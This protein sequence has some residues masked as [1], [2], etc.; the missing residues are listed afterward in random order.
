MKIR[1]DEASAAQLR[2]FLKER[3]GIDR[4]HTST[5]ASLLKVIREVGETG[6]EFELIGAPTPTEPEAATEARPAPGN[7]QAEPDDDDEEPSLSPEALVRALMDQGMAEDQAREI[8]GLAKN[9]YERKHGPD[10]LP[11]GPGK[12]NLYVTVH[13]AKTKDKF[14]GEPVSVVVNG[15]RID[16]PRG[17]DWP[18]RTPY[19][20]NLMHSEEIVYEEVVIA[21]H[22]PREYRP[23][24]VQSYPVR[25]ITPVPYDQAEARRVS[26]VATQELLRSRPHTLGMVAAA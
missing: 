17:V 2:A 9:A 15:D 5:R 20:E 13:I 7:G 3:Y 12:E 24:Y 16:I 18:I 26:Q 23:K 14:G 19:F 21:D 25:L 8:A 6:E 4:H 22:L 1:F 11:Y 10:E